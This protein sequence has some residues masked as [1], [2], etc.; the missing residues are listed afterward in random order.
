MGTKLSGVV[1]HDLSGLLSAME[2]PNETG[3]TATGSSENRE[4][5]MNL[6]RLARE[7]RLTQVPCLKDIC[8]LNR[9]KID[10]NG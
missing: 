6:L 7:E 3:R 10:E 9:R 2:G 4:V 1:A 5:P 8:K